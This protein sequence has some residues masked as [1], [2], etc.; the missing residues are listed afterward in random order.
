M[1]GKDRWRVIGILPRDLA[2]HDGVTFDDVVPSI[3]RHAGADLAFSECLWFST[4]RIYH[5]CAERFRDRR[6][7]LL[8]DAAHIH[9]PAGGQGMNTG[10][11]DAFNLGWKL[12]AVVQGAPDALLDSYAAERMPVAHRLLHTTDRAFMLAVS[13]TLTARIVRTRVVARVLALALRFEFFRQFAFGT[14]SQ[15]GIAY[16]DSPL[17][18]STGMV[19]A[20]GPRPGDRFPWIDDIYAKLDDTCFNLV[21]VGQAAPALDDVPVHALVTE[22]PSPSFYLLRPDGHVGLAGATLDVDAVT[23]YLTATIGSASPCVT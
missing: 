16:P 18:K 21:V 2:G 8:G 1:R 5:R 20:G 4:Y 23:R 15:I 19:P 9:S 13:D 22:Q 12:A 10:L 7:F 6:A 11:Q 14:V 3:R 17:S